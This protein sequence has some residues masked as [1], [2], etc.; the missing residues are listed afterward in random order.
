MNTF[1]VQT[2]QQKLAT[3]ETLPT[4]SSEDSVNSVAV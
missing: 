1:Q 3:L 4:N 2:L